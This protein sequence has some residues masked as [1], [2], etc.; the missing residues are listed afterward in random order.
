MDTE[1]TNLSLEHE[2]TN[3]SLEQVLGILRRR[4]PWIL[5]CVLLVA[6]A[7]YGVSKQ[8]TKKYTATTA[9]VF[10]NNQPGQQIAG[11][12]AA[13][14]VSASAQQ[15]TNVKLVQLGDMAEKTAGLVGQ[16]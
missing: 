6:G 12:P 16:A 3:L 5:L 9:L 8:Q 11:L 2:Q 4:V 14:S 7:A 15:S 1:Q 13:S 10:N